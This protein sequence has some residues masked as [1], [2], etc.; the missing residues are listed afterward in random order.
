MAAEPVHRRALTNIR[1]GTC[2][3]H[4]PSGR[5]TWNGVFYPKPRP[6]SFDELSYYAERFRV[7]EVN[8]TFYGQPQATVT[9][10]WAERTPPDFTFT[11]KAYQKLTHPTMFRA[12]VQRD[13]LKKLGMATPLDEDAITA[14]IAA[15]AED[16]DAFRRGIEPLGH[17]GKLGPVLLQFPASFRATPANI[18]HLTTML[19]AFHGY[20]LAVE[21]RHRTWS[22]PD[23][24]T[25]R[26][27]DNFGASSVWIDEPKFKDSIEQA[28]TPSTFPFTYVRMHGRNAA[29]W[30]RHSSAED[31][32][33]Y[34]YTDAELD[35]IADALAQ[36]PGEGY[37][38]LNNHTNGKAIANA[39]SLLRKIG[40]SA[41]DV[42]DVEA[43]VARA[44]R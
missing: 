16:I 28:W 25:M 26:L 44:A 43:T 3:W 32:Y 38:V 22:E 40:Q 20:R 36:V 30:W 41:P 21:L 37:V 27:L 5:G 33:D 9:R 6:R 19:R 1:V 15:N 10:G 31:R 13:L 14:L 11:V 35:A 4:Y 34:L 17:A 24:H 23:A 18:A 29:K 8:T 7:V 39:A 12:R 42:H 2:G